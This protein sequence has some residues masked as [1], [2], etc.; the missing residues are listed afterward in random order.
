MKS[1]QQALDWRRMVVAI[2]G[3]AVVMVVAAQLMAKPAPTAVVGAARRREAAPLTTAPPAPLFLAQARPAA[4]AGAPV[5]DLFRPLV[6][7]S[8]P[9]AGQGGPGGLDWPG[10]ALPSVGNPATPPGKPAGETKP[11]P[12]KG[13]T[14]APPPAP[15]GPRADDIQ[16]LG[17]VELGDQVQALLK[18]TSTGESRYVSKGED[19]FGFTLAEIKETEVSLSHAGQ[20]HKVAMSSAV[21]IEGPGAAGAA[22]SSGFGGRRGDGGRRR[23]GQSNGGSSSGVSITDLLA[24]PTWDARLKKLEEV[25]SQ[26]DPQQYERYKRWMTDR[27]N[28]EKM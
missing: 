19:A 5:R 20:T 23:D 18:K 28:R 13:S 8:K 15:T 14:P 2:G 10:G 25:K 7:R 24:L 11:E 6:N 9:A 12:A 3:G 17:V 1:A 21:L 4:A 22:G 26:L 16:M 27:M